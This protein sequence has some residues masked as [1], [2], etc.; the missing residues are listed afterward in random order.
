MSLVTALA[1][2]ATVD[3]VGT[4]CPHRTT[5]TTVALR[6]VGTARAVTTTAVARR[7]RVPTMTI[8]ATTATDRRVVD[9]AWMTTHRLP[10]VATLMIGM[11]D[12]TR[13]RVDIRSPILT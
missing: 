4:G 12:H 9:R 6:H 11:A 10:A 1:L 8:F 2:L 13:H 5:T 7:R 3:V